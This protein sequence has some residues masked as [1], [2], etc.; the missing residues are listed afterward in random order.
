MEEMG[1]LGQRFGP[2]LLDRGYGDLKELLALT[3]EQL[4]AVLTRDCRV[5]ATLAAQFCA[6]LAPKRIVTGGM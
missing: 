6:Q 1:A 3:E 2:L 4:M 5:S